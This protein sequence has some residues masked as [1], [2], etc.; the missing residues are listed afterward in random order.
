MFAFGVIVNALW[1]QEKPYMANA[2]GP[3]MLI[4]AVAKGFRPDMRNDTPEILSH[5]IKQ[6][7]LSEPESRFSAQ[8][9]VDYL[10]VANHSSELYDTTASDSFSSTGGT[11]VMGGLNES[12]NFGVSQELQH[13]LDSNGQAGEPGQRP[14]QRLK[15]E[16]FLLQT[17]EEEAGPP[18][19]DQL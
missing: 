19:H 3:L 15:Q 1:C 13:H 5:L 8:E 9:V 4:Q 12:H 2:M 7:W 17:K 11:H 14:I 18:R 16:R 6:C 10:A